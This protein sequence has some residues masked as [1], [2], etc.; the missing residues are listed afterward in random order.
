MARMIALAL[1]VLMF[2]LAGSAR[3]QT[4]V[5]VTAVLGTACVSVS[6]GSLFFDIASP[7][8]LT[9]ASSVVF[10]KVQCTN[11]AVA[12]ITATSLNNP[13]DPTDCSVGAGMEGMLVQTTPAGNFLYNFT[14]GDGTVTGAGIEPANRTYDAD[15]TV[16]GSV[17]AGSANVAPPGTY[18]DTIT[19]TFSL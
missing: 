17:G 2:G 6:N 15:V 3:A 8:V 12:T 1:V 13:G 14:C 4:V 16:G 10:P 19:L 11:G 5:N 7:G 18:T 9:A